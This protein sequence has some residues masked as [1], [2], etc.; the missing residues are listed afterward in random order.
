M[1]LVDKRPLS[2]Q[3]VLQIN[4]RSISLSR[5][6]PEL[7][8]L[9]LYCKQQS[10]NIVFELTCSGNCSTPLDLLIDAG[11]SDVKMFFQ[12]AFNLALYEPIGCRQYLDQATDCALLL[13][14]HRQ[15]PTRLS[16][17]W[18]QSRRPN[19]EEVQPVSASHR[20]IVVV[21]A[22]AARHISV[23]CDSKDSRRCQK[24][25]TSMPPR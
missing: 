15:R 22:E 14:V 4:F 1:R 16:P 10:Q 8:Y 23:G 11:L 25:W 19:R 17:S 18:R 7:P 3:P 2:Q 24:A 20:A 21:V 6:G 5:V 12:P 9:A 13:G